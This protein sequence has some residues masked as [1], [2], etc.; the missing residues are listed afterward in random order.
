[1]AFQSS[2][3]LLMRVLCTTIFV[4]ARFLRLLPWMF[5]LKRRHVG[6][7]VPPANPFFVFFSQVAWWGVWQR[8]Q[9]MAIG[10][11]QKRPVLFVSPT[12]A[13]ERWTR[14]LRWQRLSYIDY[15]YGVWVL[16]PMIF[17]GEYRWRWARSANRLLIRAELARFLQHEEHIHFVT[18]TPFSEGLIDWIEPEKVIYDVEDDFAAFEWAPAEG[19]AMDERLLARADVVF[20]GT[21]TL[22]DKV[23]A[24][25]PDAEF[26]PCGVNFEAFEHRDGEA[27]PDDLRILPEPRIV[28]TGTLSDRTDPS[29][30]E[31]LARRLPKASIVL[32]GPVHGSFG[33]PPEAPNLH[34]LWLKPHATLPAYLHGCQVAILPFRLTPGALAV[35]PVKTLEYLAAGCV[36][37]SSRI[38]DVERFYSDVVVFADSP[39][40]FA[41]K[42]ARLLE[43]QNDE[44]IRSGIEKARG[45]SWRA[46]IEA[47][48]RRLGTEGA[49]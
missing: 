13:H 49:D 7:T 20:T 44:R 12:Q 6:S 18:N 37:V 17:P 9:E 3:F 43:S 23:R 32:I 25:R 24:T 35:N 22:L 39:E 15:R 34:Y 40:D 29:I 28:Y 45:A 5:G 16:S 26:I 31:R 47:M 1:M 4:A 10:F 11:A 36:V 33:K 21:N 42:V 27:I 48:E 19:K 41:E 2:P 30:L 46:M 38:P 8:P 14:L